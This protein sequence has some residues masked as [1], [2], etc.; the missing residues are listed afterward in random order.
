LPAWTGSGSVHQEIRSENIPQRWEQIVF[1]LSRRAVAFVA[2]QI[3]VVCQAAHSEEPAAS[4]AGQPKSVEA[5]TAGLKQVEGQADPASLR[6]ALD[7]LIRAVREATAANVGVNDLLKRAAE[8]AQK[9][10]DDQAVG[11][12][13]DG[14]QAARAVLRFRMIREAPLPEGYPEPAPVGEI[15]VKHY[16][17]RRLA[18]TPV[19]DQGRQGDAFMTLFRHIQKNEIAMTA[20][21][22]MTFRGEPRA[23]LR[24]TDMA[25][26]YRSP[27]QGQAGKVER[28]EVVDVPATICISLGMMGDFRGGQVAQARE[29]LDAWLAGHAQRYKAAGDLRVLG[30]NSPF[31][32]AMLRY[33]EVE[34]PVR[35][36]KPAQ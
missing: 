15:V 36:L 19:T 14:L 29:H 26:L 17:A 32:P 35:E 34:I 7:E 11:A 28:V 25:F 6:A 8:R 13:R 16:P 10:P 9:L 27:A 23:R 30:Y 31:L 5:I 21:V 1:H 33:F 22:E 3:A 20:P 12:L 24:E 4:A 18:R 2:L